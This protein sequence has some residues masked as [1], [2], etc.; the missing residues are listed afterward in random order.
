MASP[1]STRVPRRLPP[2]ETRATAPG[3]APISPPCAVALCAH[4][5]SPEG[6]EVGENNLPCSCRRQAQ[7]DV[8]AEVEIHPKYEEGNSGGEL[9][10][11]RD[12]RRGRCSRSVVE[13]ELVG[14]PQ[15]RGDQPRHRSRSRWSA[16]A[17]G[18][19]IDLYT[20][21]DQGGLQQPCSRLDRDLCLG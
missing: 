7:R 11:L 8:A 12:T 15:G 9:I 19:E 10:K 1:R 2:D 4:S 18:E 21:L 16:A 5:S 3:C 20:D 6:H 13:M 14:R 17:I